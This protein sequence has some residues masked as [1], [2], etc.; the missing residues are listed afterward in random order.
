VIFE[1]EGKR[2][3]VA[4]SRGLVG[5]SCLKKFKAID[6]EIIPD[7]HRDDLDLRD[8][9]KVDAFVKL[10]NPDVIILAAAKVGSLV[11]NGQNPD[12]FYNDNIQIQNAII[13]AAATYNVSKLVFLGTSCI[14]PRDCPQPIKEDYLETGPLEK[15]NEA[16]ALAK[17][18]GIRLCQTLRGQGHDFISVMPCN[19]YG[20]ND[21]F[22][23]GVRPHV[24][25]ALMVKIKQAIDQDNP[26]ITVW[27]TGT[28]LREFLHVDDLADAIIHALKYYSDMEHINI[29]S[30]EEISI[31]DL[32]C[33]LCD[34]AGYKGDI[35]FDKS[36]P[37][38][39]P[40]KVL[41]SSKMQSLG[42]SPKITL[43]AGL[44]NVWRRVSYQG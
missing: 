19:L 22:I 30:S 24:I 6:C 36:M 34:I 13:N 38:G 15:T 41:D 4:G 18:E 9:S 12:A 40:R 7:P 28:P 43:P 5:S 39:T 20:D 8:A 26:S 31:K 29:G 11:D 32:A 23:D 42:W 27:G 33:T 1:I 10:N 37:D 21:H 44:S 2:V 17:I 25:P 35:H 3:W 14:Y 16:Y